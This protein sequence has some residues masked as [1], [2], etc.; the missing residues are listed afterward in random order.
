MELDWETPHILWLALPALAFLLWA[1][2]A[3]V[4]PMSGLRKRLLL[5]VRAL[6]VLLVLL[7]LAGPARVTES[8]RRAVVLLVDWSQ[9]MGG[10]GL[11]RINATAGQ[12]QKANPDIEWQTVAIGQEPERMASTEVDAAAWMGKQ[13][14][15]SDYA[16]AL[17]F[18]QALFPPGTSREVVIVGDGHET[19][20]SLA[21]AAQA[22]TLKGV[23]IHTLGVSGEQRPD[24]RVAELVPSRSRLHE[25]ATL[26]LDAEVESTLEGRGVLRLFEN[27]LEVDRRDLTLKKGDSQ[28]VEFERQPAGRNVYRY[29]AVVEGFAGDV[30]PAND[31]ALA[32]V[33]VRGNLRLLYAEGEP[34]EGSQ[35]VQAMQKE[36]IA[37]DRRGPGQVPGTL[38]ELAGYDGVILSD[39]AARS[40]GDAAIN[41]LREYVERLGGGLLMIGGPNAF[42]VGGYYKSPLDEVLP[43]RLRA[44]DEEEKQSSAVAIV[45]DRSGSMAGEKLE[46]AKSA[47][48]AAAE[49]L[50]RNDSIGIYAF[51][52][53]AHVVTPMTRLTSLTSIAGQIAA[54]A[55]GGGTNLEPAFRQA[56]EALQRTRAKIRHMIILTDGQTSGGGYE[57]LAAQCRAEGMTISTVAIG[58]GSHV[59]LL[60]AIASAGGGQA[61]STTD[62]S[63]ITRIFT[64]DTLMH[65]GQMLREEPFEAQAVEKSP[66]LGG[67]EQWDAP[68]LLGYVKTIR[69]ASAQVPLL[70]DTGDPLLAHWRYGLGKVTAFTSDAKSR[71]GGLWISRWQG[72]SAFWGQVLRETA[73]A[74][75]G[76]KMDIRCVMQGDDARI[77]VDVLEDAATRAD[78]LDVQ[79]EVFHVGAE[80][81]GAPL[82]T[83][84][85]LTLR[86]EGPGRY[87]G[88]F[89]PDEPGVYLV[90]AQAAGELVSA[91]LVHQP[92][93]EASLGTVNEPLL[94]QAAETSGGKYLGT[95][96]A[97]N[98][99]QSLF[100][101]GKL[102]PTPP[103]ALTQAHEE[104][105][106]LLVKL[107]LLLW[108][109]DVLI[110]RW[111]HVRGLLRMGA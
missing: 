95:I 50:G 58:E 97:G 94:R 103:T 96:G 33:D 54:M 27:G 89:L 102:P 98:S 107:M 5:I 29:R 93:S 35:F 56:R 46:T 81:L 6:C 30:M 38:T 39:I 34:A 109:V 21:A 25:G 8:P 10:S 73:R 32:I 53:E 9:S 13:G 14:A 69:K 11:D 45:M 1:E 22:A 90:R 40:V 83:V 52:S 111:E 59:G 60:Q 74:P 88:S 87:E 70:T 19:R 44:P 42:G 63:S 101:P 76:Q 28:R 100:G 92:S 62:V 36:G 24:V 43:V 26:R 15:Q 72:F 105:W 110:R 68:A 23:V 64:Q 49:V 37:L 2:S 75:Q 17:D 67:L 78:G 104:L 106:P 31:A 3:S 108:M 48:L 77:S 41:A 65:T 85:T 55:S 57:A 82:R 18:A 20:G 91:G 51:D 71:W 86:Q 16:S 47:A 80:A 12:L 4:H 61:Y 84:T 7:A 79:A 99:G 66:L